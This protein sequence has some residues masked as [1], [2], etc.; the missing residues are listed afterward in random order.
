MG[1]VKEVG[2]GSRRGRS[3]RVGVLVASLMLTVLAFQLSASLLSPALPAIAS[4]LPGGA[5]SVGQVQSLFFLSASICG[6]VV[7]R[8]SDVIGRRRALFVGL[9]MLVV[10]SAVAMLSPSLPILLVGRVLQGGA[11]AAFTVAFLV[12]ADELT[13][14]QFGVSVGVVTAVN[15]GLGGFDGVLGGILTDILGWRSLFAVIMTVGVCAVLA[16][17]MFVPVRPLNSARQRMDW[18]GAVGLGALLVCLTAW[19]GS[20][21]TAGLLSVPTVL[22]LVGVVAA[23]V[24]FWLVERRRTGALVPIV[25]LRSR[26]V[27]PLLL[28]TFL[29]VAGVFASTNFT[30]VVL[31][32]D[33][34]DGYGL[35]ATQSGLLY[36]TPTAIAGLIAATFGG[37]FAQRIGWVRSLRAAA[38]A[39][40]ALSIALALTASQ[41]WVVFALVIIL[42]V[43]Y[44]GQF[45]STTNGLGV[46]NAPAQAP[47]ALPGLV[48]A[49]Y[50]LGASAGIAAV[51]PLVEAGST[52]GYTAALWISVALTTG[53]AIAT[54]ILTA[55]RSSKTGEERSHA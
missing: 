22:W 27:W 6:V 37:W 21:S 20:I 19:I 25:A 11:S 13:P 53:G 46:V 50:G 28:S 29:T 40:V 54:L 7:A 49:S 2:R 48:G 35:S 31:S 12:L 23:A 42:G 38:A 4:D 45:Q 44:L 15:G 47:G 1:K 32:Q 39:I 30:I 16:V 52:A 41:P 26:R 33:P 36:L 43:F 51:A 18:L 8:W 17:A 9:G 10:G 55:A 5:G 14:R 24:L 3:A 34:A